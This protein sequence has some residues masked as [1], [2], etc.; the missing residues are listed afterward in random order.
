MALNRDSFLCFG[1]SK[2]SFSGQRATALWTGHLGTGDSP[3]MFNSGAAGR[4]ETI[5]NRSES[6][7]AHSPG[8]SAGSYSS[9]CALA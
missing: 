5:T 9:A 2:L 6:L 1:S 3:L 8:A 4:A 7:A